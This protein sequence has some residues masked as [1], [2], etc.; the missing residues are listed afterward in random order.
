VLQAEYFAFGDI[1]DGD[2]E[3]KLPDKFDVDSFD[4]VAIDPVTADMPIGSHAARV[5]TVIL[6]GMARDASGSTNSHEYRF[7]SIALMEGMAYELG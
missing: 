1:F 4:I 5:T 7:G 6:K 2:V 3:V